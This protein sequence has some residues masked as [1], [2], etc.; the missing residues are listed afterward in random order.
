MFLFITTLM[1]YICVFKINTLKG[2]LV[3][4]TECI[5][6]KTQLDYEEPCVCI[7]SNCENISQPP[8]EI[9]FCRKCGTRL[10]EDSNFCINCGTKIVTE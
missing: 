1:L 7:E 8:K 6:D 2:T 3:S 9:L 5:C 10:V 4:D